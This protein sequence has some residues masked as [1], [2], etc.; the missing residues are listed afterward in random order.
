MVIR[1]PNV[2]IDPD[3]EL[4]L[5]GSDGSGDIDAIFP[6]DGGRVG[7][8][9]D[10]GIPENVVAGFH[11]PSDRNGMACVQSTGSVSTKLGPMSFAIG[12]AE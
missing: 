3:L 11:I 1:S 2:S 8:P 7:E 12:E 6:D 9:R 5:A 4:G 10:F